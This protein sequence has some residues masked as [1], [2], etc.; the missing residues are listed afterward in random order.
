MILSSNRSHSSRIEREGVEENN[1]R[2]WKVRKWESYRTCC[3]KKF[4]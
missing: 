3:Q 4:T 1:P 2:Q